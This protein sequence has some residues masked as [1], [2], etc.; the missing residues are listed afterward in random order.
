MRGLPGLVLGVAAALVV[1]CAAS[2]KQ[3]AAPVPAPSRS[4][5]QGAEPMMPPSQDPRAQIKFYSDQI[6][7]QRKQL[8]M[9]ETVL[10]MTTHPT[11]ASPPHAQQDPACHAGDNETCTNMCTL[12]NSIC[13]NADKICKISDDLGD[14]EWA[15]GKCASARATC[16]DAHKRC[17]ACS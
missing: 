14:D 11:E 1:A 8:G 4:N 13:D 9:P 2:P 10:P 7:T 5:M 15:A 6:D 3:G 16:A 17:C 12:S